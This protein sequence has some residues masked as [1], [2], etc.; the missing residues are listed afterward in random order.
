VLIINKLSGLMLIVIKRVIIL[1]MILAGVYYF[2]QKYFALLEIKGLTIGTVILG[3]LG[4]FVA[5]GG[6]SLGVYA[7]IRHT[8]EHVA[9]G[10]IKPVEVKGKKVV[11]EPVAEKGLKFTDFA[12][13][14]SV[15]SKDAMKSNKSLLSVLT[16]LLI[17]EFGVFSSKTIAAPNVKIGLAIFIFF[18]VGS[19]L[20][21]KQSYNDYLIGLQHLGV[22][23]V[24][25]AVLAFVLGHYWANYPFSIL[26][27]LE[28]FQTESLVALITGTAV[29]L[30]AG[31]R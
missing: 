5:F 6:V 14:K 1:V 24:L 29:A 30:F 28:F 11:V 18:L 7:L 4:F 20:F 3:V 25:G 27:S 13:V 10:E 19:F 21:I 15:F 17:G 2:S 26:F 22:T 16:Y 31:S 23:F 12:K 9:A 8:R